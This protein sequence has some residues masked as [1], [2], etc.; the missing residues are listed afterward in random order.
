MKILKHGIVLIAQN[1]TVTF[2]DFTIDTEGEAM[3]QEYSKQMMRI[4]LDDAYARAL[5]ALGENVVLDITKEGGSV[6]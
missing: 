3:T 1:G 2:N 4:C 5:R 6:H